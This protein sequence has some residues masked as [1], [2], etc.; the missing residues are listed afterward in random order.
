MSMHGSQPASSDG[1]GNPGEKEVR[2]G[3]KEEGIEGGR[4]GISEPAK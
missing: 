4:K 2:E 3:G 1:E